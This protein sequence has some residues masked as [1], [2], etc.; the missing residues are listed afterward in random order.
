MACVFFLGGCD[1]NNIKP[2]GNDDNDGNPALYGIAYGDG[3]F[4]AVG[5]GGTIV[6]SGGSVANNY[7]EEDMGQLVSKR[8]VLHMVDRYAG[9][10]FEA[11]CDARGDK[12]MT[13]V[14]NM[15]Y[16]L[17]MI[18][19]VN[20]YATNY[21]TSAYANTLAVTKDTVDGATKKLIRT[22]LGA[23]AGGDSGKMAYSADGVSWT[24]ISNHPFGGSAIN[25]VAYGG[26]KFVA[27]GGS[28]KMAYSTGGISWTEINSTFGDNGIYGVAMDG[29]GKLVV[30]GY[31]G[32]IIYINNEGNWVAAN[33]PFGSSIIFAIAYGNGKLVA[34][35]D[36][37]K[38]AYSADGVS[39]TAV[40]NHPFG[41]NY[42]SA[43]AY[44]GG[45]FVAV[46]AGGQMAYSAD[47]VNWTASGSP[48]G[49]SAINAVAIKN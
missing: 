36:S 27:V 43:I 22:F 42:I 21:R 35:G 46:G 8:Y 25:G 6:Y 28:G 30:G 24:A 40:S 41:S 12:D 4:V 38:M 31:N 29:N 47:G 26:G 17:T 44:G 7:K 34:G 39:W 16:L 13:Q 20:G 10:K 1:G 45:K 15:I 49:S 48:F 9:T 11:A 33:H 3:K 19:R 23:V 5:S 32:K 14:P 2:G 18:D 37:G